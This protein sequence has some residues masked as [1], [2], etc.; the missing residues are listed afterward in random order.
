MRN[1]RRVVR[2]LE[3]HELTGRPISDWQRRHPPPYSTLILGLTL[4]RPVLYSRINARVKRMVDQG[5]FEEV[6]SLMDQ[7]YSLDSPAMS[8]LGY[9][10]VG[11]YLHGQISLEKAIELIK[12]GTRRFARHQR[13]W[14][15]PADARIHWVSADQPTVSEDVLAQ[16]RAWLAEPACDSDPREV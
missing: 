4:P 8:G 9:R 10:Q 7:G 1:V 14:F 13:N 16:I 5:L 2:A 3:V 11:R 12:R 15:K 6:K